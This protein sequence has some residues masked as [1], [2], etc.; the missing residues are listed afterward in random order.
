MLGMRGAREM[1]QGTCTVIK[2][3]IKLISDNSPGEHLSRAT[4]KKCLICEKE[5]QSWRGGGGYRG[6][7][8]IS[9]L[10][11]ETEIN[12]RGVTTVTERE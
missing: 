7:S 2:D 10:F 6:I 8:H 9:A 5:E 4:Y 3:E 1:H 11:S 12:M